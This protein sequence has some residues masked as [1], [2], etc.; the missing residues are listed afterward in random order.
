MQQKEDQRAV[1]ACPDSMGPAINSGGVQDIAGL[2]PPYKG[3][4]THTEPESIKRI[5]PA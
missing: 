4:K 5:L 3:R 2:I 1:P